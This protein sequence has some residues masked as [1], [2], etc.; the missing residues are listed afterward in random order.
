MNLTGK[1]HWQE[2]EYDSCPDCDGVIRHEL[3]CPSP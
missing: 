2:P 1:T 3:L